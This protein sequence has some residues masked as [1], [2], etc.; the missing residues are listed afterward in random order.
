MASIPKIVSNDQR[1]K[2][3]HLGEFDE[4]SD[5]PVGEAVAPVAEV[6]SDP[7]T[8]EVE[9]APRS[10]VAWVVG[11]EPPLAILDVGAAEATGVGLGILDVL[12]Y[13]VAFAGVVT[14]VVVFRYPM[15]RSKAC[16]APVLAI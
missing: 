3:K 13:M 12:L 1:I 5:F 8:E 4:A 16:T 15:T 11:I 2:E 10:A 14:L 9:R 7:N 6:A